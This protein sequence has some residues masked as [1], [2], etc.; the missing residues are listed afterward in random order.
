M[1]V[2]DPFRLH[3]LE[4]YHLCYGGLDRDDLGRKSPELIGQLLLDSNTRFLP[5]W[6]S[7]SFFFKKGKPFSAMRLLGKEDVGSFLDKAEL[8][9]LG[10]NRHNEAYVCIDLSQYEKSM[11]VP[12]EKFGIFGDLREADSLISGDDGSILGYARAICYWHSKNKNCAS[13]GSYTVSGNSGHTRKCENNE[14]GAIQFPR[15]DPAIIAAI[16]F[17]DKILL[18]RQADWPSG[19]L[20]VLAGFV[21]PGETPEHAV[22]R[23]IFEEAGVVVENVLYQYSQPWPFPA[24]LMLGF[25][26]ETKSSAL[27]VNK[28]EIEMASWF[29]KEE[30]DLFNGANFHLPSKLSISRR[31]I[32]D[33]LFNNKL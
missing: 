22:A 10:R 26:A 4:P 3:P 16:T 33:W 31:L 9:Y 14:C 24:S 2:F 30:I 12:L 27:T 18:G 15:T 32:D 21:E 11:L 8:I 28:D 6:H 17:E 23:E 29:T 1:A 20:S 19:M 5:I 13:C 7:L 25:T